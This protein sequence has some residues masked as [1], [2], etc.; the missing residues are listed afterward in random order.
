MSPEDIDSLNADTLKG[1]VLSL[2]AKIDDLVEQNNALHEQNKALLARV[3]EL[4]GRAHLV[5]LLYGLLIL[6]QSRREL[7]WLGVTAHPNAEWL[8][9]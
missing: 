9:R 6:R 2:L 3:A 1:L 5:W 8:A 7:L 4:E